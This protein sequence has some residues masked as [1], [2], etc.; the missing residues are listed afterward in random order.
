LREGDFLLHR[1]ILDVRLDRHQLVAELRQPALVDGDVFFDLAPSGL[2]CGELGLGG[3][4]VLPR[5]LEAG[6]ERLEPRGFLRH[7]PLGVVRRRVEALQI[8][9]PL[10]VCVHQNSYNK[11]APAL[12][13]RG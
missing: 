8:D 4:E 7:A 5:R 10:N 9:E 3:G 12:A 1:L 13:Y 11:K 6:V 2:R